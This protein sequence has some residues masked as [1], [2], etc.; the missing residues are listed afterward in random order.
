MSYRFQLSVTRVSTT[1]VCRF[2]ART[3][4]PSAPRG[5]KTASKLCS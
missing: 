2:H 5:L 3:G 4:F 1:P